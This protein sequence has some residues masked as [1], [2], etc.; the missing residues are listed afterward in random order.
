MTVNMIMNI[1]TYNHKHV[2][3]RLHN[4][5]KK[6]QKA[7]VTLVLSKQRTILESI[8]K[9]LKRQLFSASAFLV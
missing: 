1:Y 2:H 3:Q 8:T 7:E 6:L 9:R 5:L 4:K